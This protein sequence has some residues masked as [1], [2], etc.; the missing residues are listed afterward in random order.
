LRLDCIER[1]V[2]VVEMFP[3]Y[4]SRRGAF[5]KRLLVH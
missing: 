3:E 4:R 2:E 1:G 5:T